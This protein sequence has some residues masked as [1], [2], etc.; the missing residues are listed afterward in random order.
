MINTPVSDRLCAG[1]ETEGWQR[2][3]H[4]RDAAGVRTS[5][6]QRFNPLKSLPLDVRLVI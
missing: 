3:Q 2:Q 6:G 4:N 1:R 5:A